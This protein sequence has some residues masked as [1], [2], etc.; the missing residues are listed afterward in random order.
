MSK[1]G[2]VPETI[3]DLMND[4]K[5]EN[6]ELRRSLIVSNAS[7]THIDELEAAGLASHGVN[8]DSWDN[9][10]NE[11]SISCRACVLL[12]AQIDRLSSE[13]ERIRSLYSGSSVSYE[14]RCRQLMEALSRENARRTRMESIIQRQQVHIR[15]LTHRIRAVGPIESE[16][17]FYDHFDQS[18]SGPMREPAW[19]FD[20][21]DLNRQLQELDETVH[22]VDESSTRLTSTTRAAF[23]QTRNELGLPNPSPPPAADR[24]VL[25]RLMHGS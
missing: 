10:P 12:E 8:N 1:F 6:A 17:E 23:A 15:E 13:L 7:Q 14:N 25:G 24:G 9:Q 22:R 3:I 16:G 4:L 11:L 19:E 20:M 2:M 21:D 18:A 5:A